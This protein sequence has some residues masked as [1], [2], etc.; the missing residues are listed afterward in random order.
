MLPHISRKS[1]RR[2]IILSGYFGFG[3]LGDEAILECLISWLKNFT[4]SENVVV[5]SVNP[6]STSCLFGVKA[7]NRWNL[8]TWLPLFQQARLVI[9]GGGGL[10]QDTN[11]A[12]SVFFYGCQII[13]ARVLGSSVVALAQG[14]GPLNRLIS[15]TFTCASLKCCQ[16]ITV[17]DQASY[18]LL[19]SWEITGEKTADLVWSLKATP[20]PSQLEHQINALRQ[21][22]SPLVGISLRASPNFT[23][24]HLQ[25]L[26]LSIRDALPQSAQLLLLPLQLEKD[27]SALTE[28]QTLWLQYGRTVHTLDLKTLQLPSQ[29]LTLMGLLDL[30]IGMRLHAL[31]MALSQGI[32]AVGLAYDPK[33]SQLLTCF[34]QPILNLAKEEC[35]TSWTLSLKQALASR[36]T[37]SAKAKAKAE[38]QKNLSCQNFNMLAKILSMQSDY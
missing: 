17:R 4:S 10:F 19:E 18:Q 35:Q 34:E 28:F 32:P 2:L 22:G 20:L 21:Q 36:E 38:A 7:V 37:L 31:I 30:V 16:A 23:R 12:G 8:W 29:W 14:L 11:S 3:N 9:S 26:V 24:N 1:Q 13:L 25:A 33:V 5:L 6:A 27:E 15:R